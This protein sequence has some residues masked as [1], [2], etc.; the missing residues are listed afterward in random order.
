MIQSSAAMVARAAPLVSL[1]FHRGAFDAPQVAPTALY[2]AVFAVAI[3]LWAMQGIV[4]RAFYAAGD[5][6]TP[7]LGGTAVVLLT[8]PIYWFA[9]RALG[10]VGLVIASDLGI[11][12]H[13][14]LLVFLLPQRIHHCDRTALIVGVLRA[15]VVGV[16]GASSVMATLRYL[17][18]DALG[19]RPRQ[20]CRLLV[21]SMLFGVTTSALIRPLGVED[22]VVLFE[23]MTRRFRKRAPLR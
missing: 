23:R 22:A 2:V 14:A 21:G 16:I 19:D 13:T 7:M 10:I 6:L 20:W 4:S 17:P 3:P 9:H 15:V 5:T 18:L 11:L 1:L 12:F 8:V